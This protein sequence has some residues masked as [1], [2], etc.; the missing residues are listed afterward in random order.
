MIAI[1]V[2]GEVPGGIVPV[3]IGLHLLQMPD[4]VPVVLALEVAY[5]ASVS[6]S[7]PRSRITPKSYTAFFA[8]VTVRIPLVLFF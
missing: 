6:V 3:G 8:T 5:I 4:Q 7:R 2:V 1:P